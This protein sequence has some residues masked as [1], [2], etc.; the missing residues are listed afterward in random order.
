MEPFIAEHAGQVLG[1]RDLQRYQ[2]EASRDD[3]AAVVEWV[4]VASS[5]RSEETRNRVRTCASL[6]EADWVLHLS[7]S[8]RVRVLALPG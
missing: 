5:L 1:V 3:R 6:S 7:R 2:A 8:P 4:H